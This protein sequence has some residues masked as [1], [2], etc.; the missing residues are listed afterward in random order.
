MLSFMVCVILRQPQVVAVQRH[1]K[2]VEHKLYAT[3]LFNISIIEYKMQ[4]NSPKIALKNVTNSLA[5]L[6]RTSMTI[7]TTVIHCHLYLIYTTKIIDHLF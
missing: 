2:L 4:E 6:Y 3:G 7:L 1:V 5:L